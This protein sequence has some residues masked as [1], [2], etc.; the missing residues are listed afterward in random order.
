M[1][2]RIWI[3]AMALVFAFG[4]FAGG[5]PTIASANGGTVHCVCLLYT[6]PSPRD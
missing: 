6:S 1:K 2:H 5:A 4:L 3:V